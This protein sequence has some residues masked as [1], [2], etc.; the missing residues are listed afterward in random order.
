MHHARL[1]DGKEVVGGEFKQ[2]SPEGYQQYVK[3][4]G[5][6]RE[7]KDSKDAAHDDMSFFELL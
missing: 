5:E 2:R 1:S 6:R 3:K 7:R 4:R